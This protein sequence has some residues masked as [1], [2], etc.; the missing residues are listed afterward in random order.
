[1]VPMMRCPKHG[2]VKYEQRLICVECAS[3]SDVATP[4]ASDNSSSPKL[5]SVGNCEGCKR[6]RKNKRWGV[7]CSLCIRNVERIIDN[8]AQ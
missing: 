7:M 2:V 1:M 6:W 5:L 4:S 8:Y 3:E